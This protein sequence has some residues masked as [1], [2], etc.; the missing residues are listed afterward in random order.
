MIL[1]LA[2]SFYLLSLEQSGSSRPCFLSRHVYRY[3]GQR[4]PCKWL[5]GEL[6]Y[7]VDFGAVGPQV[8]FPAEP[9]LK[10]TEEN[11]LYFDIC[12]WLDSLVFLDKNLEVSS[13]CSFIY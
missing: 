7:L 6:A 13:H 9:T 11:V 2:I 4:L 10:T 3:L 8:Q 5:P 1:V 12:K